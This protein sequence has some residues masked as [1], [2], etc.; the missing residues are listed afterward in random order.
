M[1]LGYDIILGMPSLTST[2]KKY[3]GYNTVKPVYNFQTYIMLLLETLSRT[4]TPDPPVSENKGK[5]EGK[6]ESDLGV[7]LHLI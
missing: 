1:H 4:S 2:K 3:D 7:T 6:C 5:Y